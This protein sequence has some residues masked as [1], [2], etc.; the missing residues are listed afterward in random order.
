MFIT[1]NFDSLLYVFLH[2]RTSYIAR[3]TVQRI[4]KTL[5]RPIWCS[6]STNRSDK[7]REHSLHHN[8]S[9]NVCNSTMRRPSPTCSSAFVAQFN[10]LRFRAARTLSFHVSFL[11]VVNLPRVQRNLSV[12]LAGV[13]IFVLSTDA[14]KFAAHDA[15][16]I[17]KLPTLPSRLVLTV[18]IFNDAYLRLLQKK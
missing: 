15:T 12:S 5:A 13:A 10:F 17:Q 6:F 18:Q 8:S 14:G 11:L 9:A 1:E 2:V 4:L 3:H 7:G 16:N